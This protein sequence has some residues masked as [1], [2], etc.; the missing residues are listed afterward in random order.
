MVDIGSMM[1]HDWIISIT[2]WT[3][4]RSFEYWFA[5]STIGNIIGLIL[6]LFLAGI[7][8]GIVIKGIE[9]A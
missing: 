4:M 2:P 9:D 3:W 1:L 5:N 6:M 8:F 7:A